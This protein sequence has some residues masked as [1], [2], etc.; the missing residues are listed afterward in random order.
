MARATRTF[1]LFVT[2]TNLDRCARVLKFG[3]ARGSR[4][5]DLME[6][7][8]HSSRHVETRFESCQQGKIMRKLWPTIVVAVASACSGCA[9]NLPFTS[10]LSYN[11]VHQAKDLSAKD[12]GPITL[13]WIPTSFPSRVDVQGASGFVGGG[14][15][16]RVPTGIGLSSR[17]L[18]ALDAAVG[19]TDSS[20][21]VLVMTIKNAETKFEYSAGFFNATPAIDEASCNLDID[22]AMGALHWEQSFHAEAK[23]PKV[24]GS[25]QTGVVEGVWD[26]VAYQV[27]KNVVEHLRP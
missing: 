21:K 14:S 23:D 10:R 4:P 15:R 27:A 9:I 25:S 11:T 5:P 2:C 6:P 26:D 20:D 16:T 17:I 3:R 24:G 22:F 8:S 18:E 1:G 12:E 7:E 19:V 13:Q